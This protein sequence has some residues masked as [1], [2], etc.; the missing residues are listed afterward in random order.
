MVAKKE[1]VDVHSQ[2]TVVSSK[3][4][5]SVKTHPLSA[6]D[7][8]MGLHSIHVVFYYDRLCFKSFDL[9]PF[10]TSLCQVLTM[11]PPMTG[12]LTR[13]QTDDNWVLN[14]NDAGLRAFQAK[15]GTTLDEWLRLADGSRELDL[16][17]WDNMPDDPT[18]WSPFRV[19]VR[20]FD[21]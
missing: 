15:V 4:I 3:P 14:C 17:A 19:Q 11:Y 10:R 9:G 1:L 20:I 13:D 12:R 6:L 2:L 5:G 18:I 8:A 21:I 7:H 16:T